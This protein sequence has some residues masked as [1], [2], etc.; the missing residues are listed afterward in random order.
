[1]NF[2][3]TASVLSIAGIVLAHATTVWADETACTFEASQIICADG[4]NKRANI[5]NAMAHPKTAANLAQVRERGMTFNNKA[6]REIFRKSLEAKR[7]AVKR[8]AD[9]QLRKHKRGRVSADDYA[10]VRQNFAKAMEAYNAGMYL[11]RNH[12]W[13]SPLPD[14]DNSGS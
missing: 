4:S 5:F 10:V 13:R 14:N 8:H 11:Y 1:M 6:E 3:R 2:Q 12:I 7:R 9:S